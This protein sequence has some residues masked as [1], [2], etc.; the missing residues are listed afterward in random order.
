M[1][2][3]R[4]LNDDYDFDEE[5]IGFGEPVQREAPPIP[6]MQKVAGAV[7]A[8]GLLMFMLYVVGIQLV[9]G[10]AAIGATF[11]LLALG[12]SLWFWLDYKDTVPGIKHGGTFFSSAKA[13]GLMGWALGIFI[14][15]FYVVLYFYE[16]LQ[17]W[18]MPPL[19]EQPVR[20]LDP[21]A[22]LA[23]CGAA[24]KWLLYGV[25][26]TGLI[27]VYGV[28]MFMKD[29]HTRYHQ[30]RTAS[31]IFFQTAFAW[32]LPNLLVYFQQ[33]YVEFNGVW[34]LKS[35]YLWPEKVIGQFH[36]GPGI[37][38]TLLFVFAIGGLV[39][40][41]LLTYAVGKRWYCSWVCGCGALAE[42]AGDPFR[43]L[44]DKSVA[45]WRFERWSIHLTLVFT[46][47]VTVLLWANSYWEGALLGELSVG[48][49]KIHG[50]VVV[51][52]MSGLVGTGF[53]PVFGSRVW[54][55]FFCP[56]AALLGLVQRFFSRF[57]I[58]TNGG[59]CMS[60]GNCST[61]CE[62]GIDVRSYA[63]RGENIVRASCVGCGVC[64]AVCPRGVLKLENGEVGDRFDKADKPLLSLLDSM[65]S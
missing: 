41:P 43:H 13:R 45:A 57:R 17:G 20:L 52:L 34:P 18:G 7:I 51:A 54:C 64:A 25:L 53:Y 29:R 1:S 63:Q 31:I 26:Y 24:S 15:A 36:G 11:G 60:C 30:I 39:A 12:T 23:Q 42:T 5:A 16:D 2:T 3:L 47:G 56:Q 50:F 55:R 37:V 62:M 28:R 33:P 65:K 49:S 6:I 27:A 19:L 61:Y 59:Q 22:Q 40:M 58:T 4:V 48:A 38:G 32:M 14:T 21:L 46:V 9:G 8:V 35:D 10:W 44:S